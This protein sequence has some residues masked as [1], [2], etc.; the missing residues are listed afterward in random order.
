MPTEDGSEFD[1]K[2]SRLDNP[3]GWIEL[4]RYETVRLLIDALLEAPPGYQFN[5]SE[6][7]RRTG[8]SRE[9]IREHLPRL[10]ELGI[11]ERLESGAWPEYQLND[12]GKVTKELF[13]LNSAVNSVL[14]GEPKS[15]DE[16]VRMPITLDDFGGDNDEG[17]SDLHP[18][19]E[20]IDNAS[21]D[22]RD[23]DLIDQPP[24]G[25]STTNA[26]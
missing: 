14:S 11:V 18:P 13:E 15:I 2:Q 6:L 3:S 19:F 25:L 21:R 24:A 10:I 9:A 1:M 23:D 4:T 22:D 16:D 8:V 26:A 17:R 20:D 5:K 7:E 12:D